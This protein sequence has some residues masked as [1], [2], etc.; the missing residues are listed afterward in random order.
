MK[1]LYRSREDRMVAGIC[2]GI[3]EAYEIDPTLVRLG[4]V[5]LGLATGVMPVLVAYI[6]GMFIIP[7]GSSSQGN[8]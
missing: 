1:K 4:V 6:I 2:G 3:G 8:E 7:L 5:F